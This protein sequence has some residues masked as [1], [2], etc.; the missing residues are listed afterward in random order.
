MRKVASLVLLLSQGQGG[1]G[2]GEGE[3][4]G[5]HRGQRRET[6]RGGRTNTVCGCASPSGGLDTFFCNL[7][8]KGVHTIKVAVAAAATFF[9]KK[10]A[11][12]KY[13][14]TIQPLKSIVLA[15]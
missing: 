10:V 13:W 12:E 7:G 1:G 4:A 9:Q 3:D 15:Y 5:S 6:H 11:K 8:I 2:A 14:E